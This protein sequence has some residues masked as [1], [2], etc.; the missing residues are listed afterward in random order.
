MA[1]DPLM[2]Y[3]PFVP[4]RGPQPFHVDFAGP[5]VL[6][7]NHSVRYGRHAVEGPVALKEAVGDGGAAL[8]RREVE[9]GERLLGRI[10]EGEYPVQLSRLIGYSPLAGPRRVL[11]TYRRDDL[12]PVA[13]NPELRSDELTALLKDL[14]TGLAW[15]DHARVVHRRLRPEHL[16]WEG[17]PLMI[18]DFGHA[19][20]AGRPRGRP[21]GEVPWDS[22][23][24][25][26]GV[27]AADSRD[28]IHAAAVL[29]ARLAS[30]EPTTTS[31]EVA[32]VLARL[33]FSFQ[34]L[35]EG[36][37]A[38]RAADRPYARQLLRRLDAGTGR[39]V[40]R[41][42]GAD[43]QA[44]AVLWRRLDGERAVRAEFEAMRAAQHAFRAET[45]RRR[46][47]DTPGAGLWS[48]GSR[49]VSGREP[50]GSLASAL[51]A[52]RRAPAT[53][54]AVVLTAGLA[55]VLVAVGAVTLIGVVR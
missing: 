43:A 33:D 13:D 32:D 28:D 27:G 15:L 46:A 25:L 10:P 52:A 21:L 31:A 23:E 29:I 22:P 54:I 30:R 36:T 26:E 5:P 24:Q 34:R 35:L 40:G 55:L 44:P 12:A 4:G 2:L 42:E 8:L 6:R 47:A 17:G 53:A 9:I 37:R 19:A 1:T 3:V 18:A 45:A 51:R 14:L 16:R 50:R 11:V 39:G 38:P 49:A 7:G 20:E 41:A 48:A